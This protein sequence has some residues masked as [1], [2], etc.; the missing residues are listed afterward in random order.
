MV[1]LHRRCTRALELFV[2]IFD[3]N[4]WDD[5]HFSF[6][7]WSKTHFPLPKSMWWIDNL[8]MIKVSP[9]S[10][11]V[12]FTTSLF[13]PTS[14]YSQHDCFKVRSFFFFSRIISLSIGRKQAYGLVSEIGPQLPLFI[15]TKRGPKAC[16]HKLE[17]QKAREKGRKLF[18]DVTTHQ[19]EN[20]QHLNLLLSWFKRRMEIIGWETPKAGR[21]VKAKRLRFDV[22]VQ[23]IRLWRF[24]TGLGGPPDRAG[25]VSEKCVSPSMCVYYSLS[26]IDM[27]LPI[28]YLDLSS[29]Q[30]GS[31]NE[32]F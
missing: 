30:E 27:L 29:F 28:I 10:I 8:W 5:I 26:C 12:I 11:I 3:C 16:C 6:S 21:T 23:C 1:C 17:A 9:P 31:M 15:I 19:T 14:Q 4:I 2:D 22:T 7:K 18:T 20:K 32:G 24:R 13:H 25:D